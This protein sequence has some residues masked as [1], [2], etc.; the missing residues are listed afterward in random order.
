MANE[1]EA[2]RAALRALEGISDPMDRAKAT[3]ELLRE[4]PELHRELR[5][6]RQ[7]AVISAHAQ[8]RTFD[9][10]GPELGMSGDRAGQVAR[11]K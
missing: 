3:T 11:G 6:V 2:V 8:G 7:Q 10:I 1:V 4:W 9:E 5:E